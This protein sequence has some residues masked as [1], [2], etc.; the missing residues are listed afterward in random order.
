M[1]HFARE[2]RKPAAQE[3]PGCTTTTPTSHVGVLDVGSN[4][5]WSE[6]LTE[7]QLEEL[8]AEC[9]LHKEQGLL[10]NDSVRMHAVTTKTR[11]ISD[12]VGP[13]VLL[14]VEIEGVHIEA[15]VDPGS[16]STIIS[17]ETLHAI[18]RSLHHAGTLCLSWARQ[19]LSCLGRMVRKMVMSWLSLP[20]SKR[21]IC[22][23][24]QNAC[25]P[26][27]VQPNSEQDCLL[28]INAI[29]L[30]ALSLLRASGHSFRTTAQEEHP[31]ARVGW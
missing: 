8:L 11:W 19:H 3:S 27:L 6:N 26:V 31:K 28:G 7:A 13:T 20:N 25:A 1:G 14:G 22:A 9:C 4:T 17:R 30:L 23:D 10:E 24:E 5:T 12:L 16:Q 2:S 18:G 29:P 15:V 21:Q